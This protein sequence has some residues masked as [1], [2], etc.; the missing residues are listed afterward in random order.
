LASKHNKT[1]IWASDCQRVIDTALHFGKGFYGLYWNI[2]RSL[3]VIPETDDLG[4][5]TL[6]PGDT[7]KTFNQ[8]EEKGHEQ[9]AKMM[10]RYRATYMGPIRERLLK[11]NPGLQSVT[12]DELY[13]MQEMCGFEIT[14]RGSS[15]W[16]DVF[17]QGEFVSFEYARD[18]VHYYRAGPGTPWGAVMGWLWLN[19][20]TNLLIESPG[21]G[22][23]Y[24]SL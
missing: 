5:N 7:C 1:R 13:A 17:T 10:A 22:P 18:L 12:D 8:D 9:G 21:A 14:V 23:F 3:K 11:Q 24:F 20:T 16:C 19:A 6:T 15:P 2:S 4:A